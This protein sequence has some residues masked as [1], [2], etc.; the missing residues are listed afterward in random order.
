MCGRGAAD[1]FIRNGVSPSTL[2]C[3]LKCAHKR[4]ERWG[5]SPPALL[6]PTDESVSGGQINRFCSLSFLSF[7]VSSGLFS[8]FASAPISPA[9]WGGS[10]ACLGGPVVW[11]PV[12]FQSVP[13][14]S[15]ATPTTWTLVN[16]PDPGRRCLP[17]EGSGESSPVAVGPFHVADTLT[18]SH[19]VAHAHTRSCTHACTHSLAHTRSLT[20]THTH[21]RSH[22]FAHTHTLAHTL[23]HAH[24]H[25]L[26]HTR[27]HA[28]THSLKHT[29]SHTH[30]HC[31]WL[32]TPVQQSFNTG[33]CSSH[34]K[35][36]SKII[37][38][39]H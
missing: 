32:Q 16:E 26:K 37:I 18:C 2:M 7:I 13:L 38:F 30:R 34:R 23:T 22:T 3:M 12:A 17:V 5:L 39:L 33:N 4:Y 10:W 19:A 20:H 28:Q 31:V 21:T 9:L 27:S 8:S 35:N 25:S 36:T 1:G 24:T 15:G 29:R 11:Q 14:L 6:N